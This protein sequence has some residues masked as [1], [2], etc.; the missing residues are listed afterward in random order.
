MWLDS[1]D[2]LREYEQSLEFMEMVKRWK[3]VDQ[4]LTARRLELS[5]SP[6]NTGVRMQ[7]STIKITLNKFP[8]QSIN[9]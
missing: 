6:M 3:D 1:E 2:P 9:H 7:S 8:V 5:Q 4:M